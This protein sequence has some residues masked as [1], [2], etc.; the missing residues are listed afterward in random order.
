MASGA[1]T[2]AT[3]PPPAASHA[4]TSLPPGPRGRVASTLGWLTR[5]IELMESCQSRYGDVFTLRLLGLGDVVFVADPEL[6]KS[7]FTGD[8]ETMRAGE[9]RGFCGQSSGQDRCCCWTTS[10]TA[11]SAS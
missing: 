7:A 5:P 9:A 8:P 2:F 1:H 3:R 10:A 4:P 11:A 6:V